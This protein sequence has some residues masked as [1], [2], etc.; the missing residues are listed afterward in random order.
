MWREIG[1]KVQHRNGYIHVKVSG[2]DGKP[3]W[4]PESRR[5]WELTHGEIG[6]GVRILHQNG[7]RT[8]NRLSNLTWQKYNTT[9]FV[10]LPKARVLYMPKR[11][12]K[13]EIAYIEPVKD[14]DRRVAAGK[15]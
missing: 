12:E 14:F 13:K 11:R 8:D 2:D 6:E 3:K 7:D 10:F 5:N 15:R 9:K 4:M 1:T